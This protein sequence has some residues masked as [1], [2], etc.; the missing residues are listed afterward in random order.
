MRRVVRM[1]ITATALVLLLSSS[2]AA[3]GMDLGKLGSG[4]VSARA[5]APP[6]N[7]SSNFARFV[8]MNGF[9]SDTN[10]E[11]TEQPAEDLTA[12]GLD[13][14]DVARLRE[15]LVTLVHAQRDADD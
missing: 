11:A 15:I 3:R 7:D 2:A 9:V 4:A 6:Q 13:D 10:V 8:P 14:D 12:R 5:F 1:S